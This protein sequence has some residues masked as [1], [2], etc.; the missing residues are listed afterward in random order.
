LHGDRPEGERRLFA[1]GRFCHPDGRAKFL[2]EAPKPMP[3]PPSEKYPL[4]LLTGRG[5][6]SQWHTQTRTG[7]SDVLK[8]LY[9]QTL[10]VEINPADARALGVHP[11][12]WVSVESQRG[13]VRAK[14]FLTPSVPT[15]QVFLPM[16]DSTANQLTDAVFD[17][18][19]KQP[20]YKACAVRVA[21]SSVG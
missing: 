5:T 19:S 3:E 20:S 6:A 1:D 21:R 16:H 17:P 8:K 9:P 14:A 7:K 2:F 12:D 4:I 13:H 11:N 15:G 18:Y 10:H